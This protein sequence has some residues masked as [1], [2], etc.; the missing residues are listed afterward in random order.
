M[1]NRV[2][3]TL[4]TYSA[5]GHFRPFHFLFIRPWLNFRPFGISIFSTQFAWYAHRIERGLCPICLMFIL[6]AMKS[7]PPYCGVG[8]KNPKKQQNTVTIQK[9]RMHGILMLFKDGQ[10]FYVG[11]TNVWNLV[12]HLLWSIFQSV[13]THRMNCSIQWG[14]E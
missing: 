6:S 5:Y 8:G 13:V 3:I 14:S 10:K 1:I 11:P 7:F 9:P 4:I 12:D 2:D